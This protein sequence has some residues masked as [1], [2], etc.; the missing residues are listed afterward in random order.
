MGIFFEKSLDGNRFE[1]IGYVSGNGTTNETQTYYYK[2]ELPVSGINYYRLKQID[3]TGKFSF[4][5]VIAIKLD[6]DPKIE[7]TLYPNPTVDEINIR[8]HEVFDQEINLTITDINN[9]IVLQQT[10]PSSSLK[11]TVD[12]RDLS[13][14]IYSITLWSSVIR[15]KSLFVKSD[16]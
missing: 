7:Y 4:S 9:R 3:Y 10:V 13:P 2:D 15:S 5:E 16:F 6:H 8:F 1:V 12:V 14:G 11:Q